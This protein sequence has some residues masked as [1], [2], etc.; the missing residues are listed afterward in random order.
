MRY[1]LVIAIL[2]ALVIP[3]LAHP[4]DLPECSD[5]DIELASD[6]FNDANLLD[7]LDDAL[8]ALDDV[9][10]IGDIVRIL[11]EFL[12]LRDSYYIEVRDKLPQ[13][14]MALFF[15]DIYIE[16]LNNLTI[17]T[18]TVLIGV[19]ADND[20]LSDFV[21]NMQDEITSQRLSFI[22]FSEIFE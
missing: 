11:Y 9:E 21:D 3:T 2:I 8:D 18:S 15:G 6:I 16:Y 19:I 22:L 13:C 1:L 20:V 7:G 4:N 14:D 10:A 12:T 17:S 5:S